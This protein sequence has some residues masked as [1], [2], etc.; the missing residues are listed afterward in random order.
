MGSRG[1]LL[2][3]CVPCPFLEPLNWSPGPRSLSGHCTQPKLPALPFFWTFTDILSSSAFGGMVAFCIIVGDTIPHVMAA[4]FPSLPNT[5]FLWLFTNRQAVIIIFILGIS[6][7]LSL[8]R[9]ISKVRS[10]ALPLFCCARCWP[11]QLA[12]ASTLALISMSV[13]IITI[14][15]QGGR[16]SPELRGDLRGSL[17]IRS[18]FFQAIGVISFGRSSS[19][20]SRSPMLI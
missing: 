11:S 17:F 16:V 9:D 19:N 14:S 3:Q 8:Y 13:I 15:I 4:A 12:K 2:Y 20:F 1:L 18:G 7:P 5:P 6:Y 10:Y